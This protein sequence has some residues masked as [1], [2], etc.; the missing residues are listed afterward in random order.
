MFSKAALFAACTTAANAFSPIAFTQTKLRHHALTATGS[1]YTWLPATRKDFTSLNDEPVNAP[2]SDDAPRVNDPTFDDLDDLMDLDDFMDDPIVINEPPTWLTVKGISDPDIDL[3][4]GR[5]CTL[6]VMEL[7]LMFGHLEWIKEGANVNLPLTASAG[8]KGNQGTVLRVRNERTKR[9]GGLL[10]WSNTSQAYACWN[11]TEYTK[12]DDWS[13][14]DEMTLLDFEHHPKKLA[15]VAS[16]RKVSGTGW[17]LNA[18]CIRFGQ[19]GL[20]GPRWKE[21]EIEYE[22]EGDNTITGI[23]TDSSVELPYTI[24]YY[25]EDGDKWVV[26]RDNC[27]GN[28]INDKQLS[29]VKATKWRLQ[30]AST[31]WSK[32]EGLSTGRS[33]GGIHAELLSDVPSVAGRALQE[34]TSVAAIAAAASS[35][36]D[37]SI[38]V[39]KSDNNNNGVGALRTAAGGASVGTMTTALIS[40]FGGLIGSAVLFV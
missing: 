24:K 39:S 28:I 36:F 38:G 31:D 12:S 2:I 6:D 21:M 30:W 13:I 5:F 3:E 8:I 29:E 14:G 17:N 26:F 27:M 33:A 40:L 4:G 25:Q 22:L 23:W 9:E 16:Y 11:P 19:C 37:I 20:V 15:S 10:L 1:V 18:D 34:D 35:E 32:T 7:V